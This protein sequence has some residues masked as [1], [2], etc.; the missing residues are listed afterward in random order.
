MELN[1]TSTSRPSGAAYFA[2]ARGLR[3][4][5]LAKAIEPV[6]VFPACLG[7]GAIFLLTRWLARRD[8][9]SLAALGWTRP[10]LVDCAIGVGAAAVIGALNRLW[11]YPLVQR[12]QPTFD[13]TVPNVPLPAVVATLAVAVVAEDTLYRG[14]GLEL[15]RGRH[16]T[17]VAV[18]VTSAFYALVAPGGGLP[19]I[20]WAFGFG[21]AL[22][23]LRVWRRNLWPVCIAHVLVSVGPRLLAEVGVGFQ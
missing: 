4:E 20:V 6:A 12:W 22:G 11:L 16:G 1:L 18:L 19:L 10:A 15:L 21:I 9:L 2:G 8:G 5:Q 23:S 14:Y 7:F 17:A 3:G 13:P